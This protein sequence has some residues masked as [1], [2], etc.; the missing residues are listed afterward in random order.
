MSKPNN[1]SF[2]IL[3]IDQPLSLNERYSPLAFEMLIIK[4]KILMT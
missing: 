1:P 2:D 4:N 3:F